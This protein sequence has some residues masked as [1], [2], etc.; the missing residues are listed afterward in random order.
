MWIEARR[1]TPSSPPSIS[2]G[3]SALTAP[4]E[5]VAA[6][7]ASTSWTAKAMSW[8]PSPCSRTCSAISP[9]GVSGAVKTKRM[10]FWTMTYEARSRTFVSRPLN[11]TGVKPHRAR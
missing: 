1:R 7:A 11:A 5:V 6:Q 10:S 8:T 3:S 9:S 2:V 4:R